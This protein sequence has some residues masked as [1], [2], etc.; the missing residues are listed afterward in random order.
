MSKIKKFVIECTEEQFEDL[1]EVVEFVIAAYEED[2][3][4]WLQEDHG[5]D[6]TG[7]VYSKACNASRIEWKEVE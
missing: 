7:H 2:F 3:D 4:N 5:A 1:R 6:D